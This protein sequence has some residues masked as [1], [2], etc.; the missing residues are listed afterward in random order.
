[1]SC[2]WLADLSLLG[3]GVGEEVAGIS[4]LRRRGGGGPWSSLR[5]SGH[6]TRWTGNNIDGMVEQSISSRCMVIVVVVIVVV[7]M[8][9]M[10]IVVVMVVVVIVV[11]M[12]VVVGFK[13][14]K[15]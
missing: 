6:N 15:K 3:A 4:S 11:V 5:T 12:M 1:M 10:V 2:G 13:G 8:V 9:V 7:M 14:G